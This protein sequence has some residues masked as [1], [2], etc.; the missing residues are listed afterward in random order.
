MQLKT[1]LAAIS[2]RAIHGSVDRAVDGIAYDSRRVQRNSLFVALR[3]EKTDG[4]EFIEQAIEKGATVIVAER[5]VEHAHATG[6]QVKN[7]RVAL[8]DLGAVFYERPVRRLKMAGV[9]HDMYTRGNSMRSLTTLRRSE[10]IFGVS[11]LIGG[12]A[13]PR[14][15]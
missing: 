13:G 3:G 6:V 14:L 1:L 5:E 4:H 8:A 10:V 2:P 15:S 9:N 12:T 11:T 7:T